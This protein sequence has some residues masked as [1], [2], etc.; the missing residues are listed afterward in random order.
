MSAGNPAG[1]KYER[2]ISD[3]QTGVIPA[4]VWVKAAIERHVNDLKRVGSPDFPY[5]FDP[6]EA[7][8]VIDFF[9]LLP[10]TAGE[11]AKKKLL[12]TL[13]DW[14]CFLLASIVGWR[15]LK[16]G[17]RFSRAYIEI[18]KKNGKTELGAGL[19]AYTLISGGGYDG[20]QVYS[21][22]TKKDQAKLSFI[23]AQ[24]MCRRLIADG[25]SWAKP[26][27]VMG[28]MI[29][30]GD[31]RMAAVSSDKDGIEG[32][33]PTFALVDE[34]HV[35]S[36]S[37]LKDNLESATVSQLAAMLLIITTAGSNI[38]GPCY[39]ERETATKVLQGIIQDERFFSLIYGLDKDDDFNDQ[40]LWKKAI[41]NLDVSVYRDNIE[42][43]LQRA[44]QEGA[45]KRADVLTKHFGIWQNSAS[46]W[47]ADEVY[48]ECR[49][50]FDM[51][52][53][54]GREC[55][56]GMDFAANNDFNAA[57]F[58]F[59]SRHHLEQHF[60]YRKVWITEESASYR[61]GENPDF[62]NWFSDEHVEITPG[63]AADYDKIAADMIELSEFFRFKILGF[64]RQFAA[65][66]IP[67]LVDHGIECQAFQQSIDA[68]CA[69]SMDIE[70]MMLRQEIQHD[71][72]PCLRWMY[73]NVVLTY[74][75]KGNY[76]PDKG[77]SKRKKIDGV[78]SDVIAVGMWRDATANN[79]QS[80]L[81]SSDMLFV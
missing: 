69:P 74:N 18:T 59:P 36:T 22:A 14:Q 37:E 61:G 58:F 29:T 73:S 24:K 35:H 47:I 30:Y 17:R 53:F 25:Y 71:G 4:N 72:N 54:E 80:Y 5:Y 15:S 7:R 44:L 26:M 62:Q 79:K 55:Y 21:A 56:V 46:T 1:T 39:L 45:T 33:N 52:E 2:Y 66:I 65:Y 8:R 41:P 67:K 63:N 42:S 20:G 43:A 27:R 11:W 78:I 13:E 49:S 19:M 28:N 76:R 40:T 23:A 60:V 10:Y 57:S 34:Y 6:E 51:A 31:A 75:S 38:N 64:D 9:H 50:D 77:K 3:I 32:V 16:G 81:S 70:R 68:M 48:Q 12:L